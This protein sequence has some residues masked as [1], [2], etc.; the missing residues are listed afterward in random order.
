MKKRQL[1]YNLETFVESMIERFKIPT[2]KDID[3]LIKKTEQSL[4]ALRLP[5]RT[6]FNKLIK[7]VE[8]LEKAVEG[9]KKTARTA[10][11]AGKPAKKKAAVKK[12]SVSKVKPQATDLDKVLEIVSKYPDGA[13]VGTLKAKSGFEDKKIRNIVF[14]LSK[15][16]EI[17]RAGRGVYKAKA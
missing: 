6:E 1:P 9:Q 4:S 2:K 17:E 14:R 3:T 16:G 12:V 8:A 15:K 7:R 13:D 10:T 11:R 5:K